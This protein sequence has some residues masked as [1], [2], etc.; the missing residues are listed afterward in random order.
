[1]CVLAVSAFSE[2]P[3]FWLGTL[4]M[5]QLGL[6]IDQSDANNIKVFYARLRIG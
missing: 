4:G 5:M 3:A 6:R 1:V 2:E